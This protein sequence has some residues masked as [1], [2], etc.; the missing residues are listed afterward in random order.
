M[1]RL[2][3]YNCSRALPRIV[4]LKSQVRK[5]W[6]RCDSANQTAKQNKQTTTNARD[7]T[8]AADVRQLKYKTIF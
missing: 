6:Q 7:I 4:P 5:T 8:D 2:N 1:Q 3:N